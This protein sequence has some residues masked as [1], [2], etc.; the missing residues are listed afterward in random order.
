MRPHELLMRS[1]NEFML[2][3]KKKRNAMRK[4]LPYLAILLIACSSG[5]GGYHYYGGDAGAPTDGPR[6]FDGGVQQ[7]YDLGGF[8]FDAGDTTS[9]NDG[10]KNGLETD[11]D[12]GG[13]ICAPCVDGATCLRNGDCQSASCMNGVCGAGSSCSD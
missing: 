3:H 9:C 1:H 4:S 6:G 10:I 7:K 12:C 2:S 13:G 11:V 5:G 8:H